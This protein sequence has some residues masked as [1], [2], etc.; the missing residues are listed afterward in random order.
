M[1]FTVE[2][3]EDLAAR[4]TEEASARGLSVESWLLQLADDIAPRESIAHLQQRDP[5]EW[6]R[7]FRAWAASHDIKAAPLRLDQLGRDSLYPDRV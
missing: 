7:Q 6:I 3:P 2:I 1:L 5:Q 4:L